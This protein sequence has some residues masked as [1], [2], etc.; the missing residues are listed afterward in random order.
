[1]VPGRRCR[2]DS[3]QQ[4][5]IVVLALDFAAAAQL[6]GVHPAH[7]P[8]VATSGSG[9]STHPTTIRRRVVSAGPQHGSR[10]PPAG[11][12]ARRARTPSPQRSSLRAE[13]AFEDRL[14]PR[15]SVRAGAVFPECCGIDRAI[16]SLTKSSQCC[17]RHGRPTCTPRRRES[18]SPLTLCHM[19]APSSRRHPRCADEL[20]Q[21]I[22][23]SAGARLAGFDGGGPR[24]HSRQRVVP[25]ARRS[26]P[27]VRSTTTP[28]A[29][30][31]PVALGRLPGRRKRNRSPQ[32]LDTLTVLLGHL[33]HL[34]LLPG[35]WAPALG[36]P[37][38]A[39]AAG[40]VPASP[41]TAD[42]EPLPTLAHTDEGEPTKKARACPGA[43]RGAGPNAIVFGH[44]AVRVCRIAP[45]PASTGSSTRPSHALILRAEAVSV[46]ARR[47]YVSV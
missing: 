36:D 39:L 40:V 6:F 22:E 32:V 2:L 28:R 38:T 15:S 26:A 13:I 10:P 31:A 5:P 3:P 24:G 45:P 44:D 8:T 4:A 19:N 27:F 34:P 46:R 42:P 29:S 33:E 1:M 30:P 43:R 16:R 21:L 11:L 20:G 47:S 18:G 35:A 17:F 12:H 9:R 41:S 7:P 23:M 37:A 14:F 25:R